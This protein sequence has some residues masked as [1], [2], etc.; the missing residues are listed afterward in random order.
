MNQ[1]RTL[2]WTRAIRRIVAFGK[3]SLLFRKTGYIL[4]LQCLSHCVQKEYSRGLGK[5]RHKTPSAAHIRGFQIPL[6]ENFSLFWFSCNSMFKK[7]DPDPALYYKWSEAGNGTH[8]S[9]SKYR[10]DANALYSI[11]LCVLLSTKTRRGKSLVG[12][13]THFRFFAWSC[14]FLKASLG[15]CLETKKSSS[16]KMAF[17][18]VNKKSCLS[19]EIAKFGANQVFSL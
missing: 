11:S 19:F 15:W 1:R 12:S 17:L 13:R 7:E 2:S 6:R 5:N 9:N 8:S 14:L 4:F 18:Q 10:I 16:L 3:R